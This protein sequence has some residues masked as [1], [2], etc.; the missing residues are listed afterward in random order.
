MAGLILYALNEAL[1]LLFFKP[2]PGAR[3]GGAMAT[4]LF[5]IFIDDIAT[6]LKSLGLSY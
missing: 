6:T 1:T 5:V 4:C 3:Q 2:F